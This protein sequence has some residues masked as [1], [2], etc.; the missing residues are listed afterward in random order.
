MFFG[1]RTNKLANLC[2]LIQIPNR[3]ERRRSKFYIIAS[4]KYFKSCTK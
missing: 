4:R 3:L 2:N 1:I